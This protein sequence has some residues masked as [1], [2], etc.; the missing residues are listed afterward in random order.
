[1]MIDITNQRIDKSVL[2]MDGIDKEF[3]RIKKTM[4]NK[5]L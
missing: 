4:D 5:I 2:E 3:K 1:M